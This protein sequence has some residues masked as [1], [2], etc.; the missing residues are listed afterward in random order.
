MAELSPVFLDGITYPAKELRKIL[1][2]IYTEGILTSGALAISQS[3]TPAMSVSV[4][5][6]RAI[7]TNDE[8]NFGKYV[9]ENDAA[10]TKT[11]AASDPSNPR[12]DRIIAQIYD[13][14]DISGAVNSWALEVLTGTPAASP[15]APVLPSN[16]ISFATVAVAANAVTI[17]NANITST[18]TLASFLPA[19]SG[20][21]P[22]GTFTYNAANKITVASGA[23][24]IYQKSDKLMFAQH[25][26]IK[27]MYVLVVADT[28]LT[29][30][31]GTDAVVEDTATYPITLPYYS[32]IENPLGFTPW[33]NITAPVFNVASYDNG[34]GGQPTTTECRF[35]ISGNLYTV[36]YYGN[37]V[38]AG[39]DAII[40]TTSHSFITPLFTTN[41]APIGSVLA[42]VTTPYGVG[43]V[44]ANFG[45]YFSANI[46]DN[47]TISY[48]GFTVTYEI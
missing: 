27:K 1:G 8:G 21:V 40:T 43:T 48:F 10:V 36:H 29:V 3:G 23:A 16:A 35:K 34:A 15:S 24:S 22:A 13:A 31:A 20:W 9:I 41:T 32:H 37:G 45:S 42:A 44:L 7:V 25:G 46:T 47:A 38:K 30:T 26:Y 5:L 12:I 6:G 33:F 28:L 2:D 39:T 17:V 14:T 19:I 11:I 18:R 4:A